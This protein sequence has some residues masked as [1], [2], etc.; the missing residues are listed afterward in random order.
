VVS[1]DYRF[2]LD[3]KMGPDTISSLFT[4]LANRSEIS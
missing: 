3:N 1:G 2:F 4:K